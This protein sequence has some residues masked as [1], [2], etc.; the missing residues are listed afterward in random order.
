[1][2][3]I[4]N[5]TL[6]AI[7]N[8]MKFRNEYKISQIIYKGEDYF[9]KIVDDTDMIN[10]SEISKIFNFSKSF[11]PFFFTASQPQKLPQMSIGNLLNE[12]Q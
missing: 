8:G 10:S 11:D 4:R 5:S 9:K 7:E 2:E 3:D 1:M 6:F 12:N